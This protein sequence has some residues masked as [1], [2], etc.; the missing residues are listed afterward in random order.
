MTKKYSL[1]VHVDEYTLTR[2][3]DNRSLS[4]GEDNARLLRDRNDLINDPISWER[5]T[6]A[7]VE[8]NL[9]GDVLFNQADFLLHKLFNY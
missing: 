6:R 5:R 3:S 8:F 2:L 4:L 9:I 1:Q 7:M